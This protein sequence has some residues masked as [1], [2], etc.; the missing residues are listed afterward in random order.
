MNA[1]AMAIMNNINIVLFKKLFDQT[2]FI[3]DI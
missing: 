2:Y 3:S 1:L